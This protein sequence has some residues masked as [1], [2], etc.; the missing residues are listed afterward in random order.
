MLIKKSDQQ[1][2]KVGILLPQSRQ[3]P[4]AALNFLNGMKLYFTINEN[5][6]E[7]GRA[8]L[9]VEDVGIGTESI[10]VEKA[11][12]LMVQDQVVAITGLLEP[13]IGLEV[14]KMTNMADKPTLFSG[15][16]ESAISS[17]KVSKNLY[18]NTLQF[19]QSYFLLGQY[20]AEN[21]DKPINI[22]TSFYDCGYDP[23]K[24]FRLGVKS[25]GRSIHE[26]VILKA[27][28]QEELKA[29]LNQKP[30]SGNDHLYALLLHPNM[31]RQVMEL[32]SDQINEMVTTPFYDGKNSSLKYWAFPD[33]G[34][35]NSLT[36]KL[37]QATRE[38]FEA[39]PDIFS[40]LGYQQ[41]QLVYEAL[42]NLSDPGLDNE[43][44]INTWKN[45][46]QE[47]VLGRS[48]FNPD[49][50]S[51]KSP[52]SVFKGKSLNDQEIL[53]VATFPLY[54]HHEEMDELYNPKNAYTNPYMFF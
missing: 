12:K 33:W 39:E 40:I 15:L 43:N 42:K 5:Y 50:H 24:A 18:F 54:S 27:E 16:G 30:I 31:L 26:E 47:T 8:E 17:A 44:I 38:Y 2:L 14:A 7:R 49:D 46:D 6:F 9:V 29:E 52:I 3:Y 23:L 22:I 13:M 37:R 20:I 10:S 34:E 25:K 19:W 51:L 11:H 21:L 45:F 28:N 53:K 4:K 41:G 48:F 32:S 36:D 1:V 35:Q